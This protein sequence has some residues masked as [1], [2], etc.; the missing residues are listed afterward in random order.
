MKKFLLSVAALL[1]CAATM[2]SITACYP[3]NSE[4]GG[5][6]I[7]TN[8]NGGD[9]TPKVDPN[10]VYWGDYF[11]F[12]IS[13]F[14]EIPN[15]SDIVVPKSLVETVLELNNALALTSAGSLADV[16]SGEPAALY[17]TVNIDFAGRA[18][19]ENIVISEDILKGMAA[20]DY[21]IMIGSGSFIGA[22]DHPTDDSL[23]TEGFEDQMVGIKV[24]ETKEILVTFPENYGEKALAGVQTIF[25]ITIN[26]AK[27]P[28]PIDDETAKANGYESAEKFNEQ[29]L[30]LTK[31]QAALEYVL[32][33]ASIKEY[34]VGELETLTEYYV[35]SYVE[36]FYGYA[37]TDEQVEEV[38]QMYSAA[39]DEWAKSFSKERMTFKRIAEM[40]GISITEKELAD[41]AQKEAESFG[42]ASGDTLI[43]YY[44][45]DTVWYDYL[46]SLVS[47]AITQ[48]VQF[49]N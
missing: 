40:Q 34:P 37:P 12:D 20:E 1:L 16:A 23:D 44:G 2:L 49:E 22:Y 8:E 31:S 3:T 39:A 4:K 38:R 17:D 29:V 43:A 28:A 15:L 45:K 36:Y 13:S 32:R 35:Q 6:N 21:E 46:Y 47:A 25:T 27:R 33:Q 5:D 14:I 18:K 19:D 24:G 26:S 42:I 48:N 41:Y 7:T 9:D 30:S 11:D 10:A